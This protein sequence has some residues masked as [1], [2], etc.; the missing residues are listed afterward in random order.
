MKTKEKRGRKKFYGEETVVVA[1]KVPNSRKEEFKQVVFNFLESA[2]K[3]A[4]DKPLT[5][6][7]AIMKWKCKQL[8]E[9]K[10]LKEVSKKLTE[11]IAN[12]K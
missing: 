3:E 10:A 1:F 9:A 7:P 8:A 2:V 12:R 11:R 5:T 6:L 4:T